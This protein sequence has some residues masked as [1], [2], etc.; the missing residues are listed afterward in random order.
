TETFVADRLREIFPDAE[1]HQNY[2][3]E[4]GQLE[5]DILVRHG[6]TVVLVECKNRRVRAFAGGRDDLLKYDNDF[7]KSVQYAY[8]QALDVKGRVSSCDEMV[9]FDEKGREAFRLRRSEV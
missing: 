4:R 2:Y 7:E 6:D 5:K 1:I 9:F 3:V 8:D